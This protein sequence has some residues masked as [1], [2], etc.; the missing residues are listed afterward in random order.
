FFLDKFGLLNG[1]WPGNVRAAAWRIP[2]LRSK[3]RPNCQAET[4]IAW[5]EEAPSSQACQNI[6]HEKAKTNFEKSI[7]AVNA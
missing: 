6:A 7:L 4:K 1:L 3:H 5:D 2:L